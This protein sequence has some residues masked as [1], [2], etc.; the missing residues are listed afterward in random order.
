MVIGCRESRASTDLIKALS[1][2]G[3]GAAVRLGPMCVRLSC[4]RV[5]GGVRNESQVFTIFK[6]N[7]P[8]AFKLS[9]LK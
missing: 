6:H 1:G 4:E 8:V 5:V 2:T 9:D 3:R 7:F